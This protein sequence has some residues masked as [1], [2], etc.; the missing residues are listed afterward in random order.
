MIS[1]FT[2]GLIAYGAWHLSAYH[3]NGFFGM[4][5]STSAAPDC[6]SRIASPFAYCSPVS[7][8]LR[9]TGLSG[10]LELLRQHLIA[11]HPHLSGFYAPADFRRR[12]TLSGFSGPQH[13]FL[14]IFFTFTYQHTNVYIIRTFTTVADNQASPK[15]LSKPYQTF[16]DISVANGSVSGTIHSLEKIFSDT[17]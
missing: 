8:T 2:F 4:S 15:L 14:S 3:L 5:S 9:F 11:S 17:C 7:R 6:I 13:S 12:S 1:R 16:T 10:M